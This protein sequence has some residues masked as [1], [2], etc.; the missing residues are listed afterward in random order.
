[1]EKW[2]RSKPKRI[3]VSVTEEFYEKFN[4]Y[5]RKEDVKKQ[6]LLEECLKELFKIVEQY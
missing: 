5:C 6:D 4:T 2:K 1:M 3:S